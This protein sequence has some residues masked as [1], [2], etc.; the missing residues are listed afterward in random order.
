[1]LTVVAEESTREE[2][3]SPLDEIWR[4]G[5][6]RMLAAALEAEA[7]A[8]VELFTE[9]LD[10]GGHRLVRKNGHAKPRTITT[11]SGA[12]EIEAPRIDDRRVDESSGEKMSFKSSIVPPWCRKSPE[13]TEVLPLMYL[14]GMSTGDFARR[15]S[16]DSSARPRACLLLPSTASPP[17]GRLNTSS[18]WSETCRRPTMS[19]CGS[20][21][22][23][24]RSD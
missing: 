12:I 4:R 6:Q 21:A 16:R 2:L 11:S 8:Y 3:A 7:D 22:S 13:V 5:A 23:T 10:Q 15:P 14:H 19:T 24:R 18:S 9:E 20:T 1:M 17:P